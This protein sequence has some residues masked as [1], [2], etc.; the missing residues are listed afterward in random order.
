MF[1]QVE[2][3]PDDRLYHRFL[4][5]RSATEPIITYEFLRLVFS[6]KASPYFAG[7]VLKETSVRFGSQA[8]TEARRAIDNS[9]Y[10][11][12][13]LH[14][15]ATVE[16]GI[17][18]RHDTQQMLTE[19]GF[20]LRKWMSNSKDVMETVP[21]DL[22]T[23]GLRSRWSRS[24]SK[25]LSQPQRSRHWVS[26][27]R[28]QRM[29]SLSPSR[30]Q[31]TS[32]TLGE[33]SSARCAGCSTLVVSSA[34]SLS[35]L[36][37]C[38]RRAVWAVQNGTPLWMSTRERS[39]KPG[40]VRCRTS[41]L[42]KCH[43]VSRETMLRASLLCTHLLMPQP[44]RMR[45]PLTFGT[46]T[47]TAQ[48]GSLSSNGKGQNGPCASFVYSRSWA[49]RR[50]SRSSCGWWSEDRLG[51]FISRLLLLAD[52]MNVIHWVRSPSRK[53]HVEVGNRISE[54]QDCSASNRWQHISGKI[55]PADKPTRGLSASQLQSDTN[56]WH[57][58]DFIKCPKEDWPH[59]DFV[60][61]TEL[62]GQTKKGLNCTFEASQRGKRLHP[63]DFSSWSKLARVTAWT[64][65]FIQ[66][67]RR[68][69]TREAPGKRAGI[70]RIP[71]KSG[72]VDIPELTA[73]VVQNAKG[74]W[75]R[76]AQQESYE[77]VITALQGK[78]HPAGTRLQQLQ[79]CMK[80]MDGTE[81]LVVG[82]RQSTA[83]HLPS[84]IHEPIILPNG[85][86]V[87]NL[88]IAEEDSKCKHTAGTNHL[89]AI[90]AET[91]WIV[92]GKATV[93]KHQY[94]CVGCGKVYA[95]AA[96]PQMAPLRRHRALAL[97]KGNFASSFRG[98]PLPQSP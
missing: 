72:T 81:L 89:L 83:H 18:V 43:A 33:G 79:P 10:V 94:G 78:S 12:G 47:K 90:L 95:K 50:C 6:V 28:L 80:P 55:N 70:V 98:L 56:W 66:S 14:S 65:R 60:V 36:V 54:V 64:Q 74:V 82:G 86:R 34:L 62:R 5:Q 84:G 87:T 13:L 77:P 31:Q 91:Y 92:K 68:S 4:W 52:S 7:R 53:F 96:Q 46:P 63:D 44:Q 17:K 21:E 29:N 37:S 2:L 32:P 8:S 85:H 76:Q 93:K 69:I 49:T 42:S 58:P 73:E 41:A 88:I 24:R 25:I 16:Q 75:I 19:G 20:T 67:C 45:P 30:H 51:D 61:P 3:H 23:S 11:D 15:V 26:P 39:G 57:G 40:L 35:G 38:S 97:V 71:F 48:C 9:F 27:G 59:K 1:L 22:R